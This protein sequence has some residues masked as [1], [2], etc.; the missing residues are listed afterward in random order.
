LELYLLLNVSEE[1]KDELEGTI[2]VYQLSDPG[3]SN[4]K[5]IHY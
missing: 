3:D 4:N 5:D 2:W 1:Q